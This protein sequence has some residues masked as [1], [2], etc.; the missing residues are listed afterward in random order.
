MNSF[1]LVYQGGESSI[2]DGR[3]GSVWSTPCPLG[4]AGY[5]CTKCQNGTYSNSIFAQDC[6]L[7]MNKLAKERGYYDRLKTPQTNSNC[8]YSCV[9]GITKVQENPYCL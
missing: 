9:D 7:C 4:Y 2:N 5:T 6:D 3:N 8:P 1:N